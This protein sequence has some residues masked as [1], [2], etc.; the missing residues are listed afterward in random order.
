MS[1]FP[2]RTDSTLAFSGIG[3]NRGLGPTNNLSFCQV[4]KCSVGGGIKVT[5][6]KLIWF[7]EEA[8]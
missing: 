5:V 4:C 7:A 8:L 6:F 2:F 3:V 1:R